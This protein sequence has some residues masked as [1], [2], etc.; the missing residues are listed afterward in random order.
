MR[1]FTLLSKI[2]DIKTGKKQIDHGKGI[3]QNIGMMLIPIKLLKSWGKYSRD[4][5]CP[6]PSTEEYVTAEEKYIKEAI[7]K[8]LWNK[9]TEYG[10]LRYELLDFIEEYL[11]DCT[12]YVVNSVGVCNYEDCGRDISDGDYVVIVKD[13]LVPEDESIEDILSKAYDE[14][15][16]LLNIPCVVREGFF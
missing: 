3:C 5:L 2:Q 1:T 4:Y 13:S 15:R 16:G 10:R 9:D 8:N 6:V 11:R 7:A 12:T 14:G